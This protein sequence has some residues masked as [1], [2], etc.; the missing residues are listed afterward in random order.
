MGKTWL[1]KKREEMDAIEAALAERIVK[2]LKDEEAI[3]ANLIQLIHNYYQ[4]LVKRINV[5][6]NLPIAR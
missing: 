1:E 3:S 5:I 2:E 6:S 4:Y